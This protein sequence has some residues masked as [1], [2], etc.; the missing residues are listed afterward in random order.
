MK[1]AYEEMK[2]MNAVNTTSLIDKHN[3]MCCVENINP[4]FTAKIVQD[5]NW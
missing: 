2:I 5:S 4:I 1:N 3:F